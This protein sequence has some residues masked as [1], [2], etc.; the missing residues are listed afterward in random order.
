MIKPVTLDNVEHY[1][2]GNNLYVHARQGWLPLRRNGATRRFRN[3]MIASIPV[4]F[5]PFGRDILTTALLDK[6]WLVGAVFDSEKYRHT[7]DLPD[8]KDWPADK[9][10]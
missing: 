4:R 10:D 9:G 5:G 3:G 7:L 8:Y 1:L 2:D 6:P